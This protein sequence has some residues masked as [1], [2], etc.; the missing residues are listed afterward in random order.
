MCVL[1]QREIEETGRAMR[2]QLPQSERRL[3][4][5]SAAPCNDHSWSRCQSL[6][7]QYQE[8][9]SLFP[10]IKSSLLLP[11]PLPAV[12]NLGTLPPFYSLSAFPSQPP[13]PPFQSRVGSRHSCNESKINPIISHVLAARF[14]FVRKTVGKSR[15]ETQR[16]VKKRE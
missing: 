5:F 4:G 1:G 3:G 13:S 12:C 14:S 10:A 16:W 15:C 6:I 2:P 11:L 8:D 7:I 9:S